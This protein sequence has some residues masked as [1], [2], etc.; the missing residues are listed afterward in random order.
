MSPHEALC[1]DAADSLKACPY[2]GHCHLERRRIQSQAGLRGMA[3]WCY[4]QLV[5]KFAP[6]VLVKSP[7]AIEREAFQR[8]GM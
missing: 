8:E 1:R 2:A 4:Q 5:E 7:E 3:C 6:R